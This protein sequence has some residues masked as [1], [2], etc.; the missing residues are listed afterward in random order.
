MFRHSVE[1]DA[2]GIIYLVQLTD[3]MKQ[4]L[5]TQNEQRRQAFESMRN[6]PAPDFRLTDLHGNRLSLRALRGKLVVLNFWFT[7]C[8]PC[9]Q[10]KP[11]LNKL[12]RAYHPNDVVFLALTFNNGDQ[13]RTFLKTHLR[14]YPT[15]RF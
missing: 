9:I 5:E 12:K 2:N 14:L 3:E 13:V 10:E 11:E 6:K 7:S 8:A 1:D 4:Q 15:T